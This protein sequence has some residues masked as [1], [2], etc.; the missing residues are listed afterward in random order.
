MHYQAEPHAEAKLIRCTAGAIH[1]VIID[2]R[3][4]SA[5]YTRWD[6]V[7]LTAANRRLLFVPQGFAH[8]FLTLADDTEVFYQISAAYRPEA[9]RGVRWNDPVFGIDW[10][11]SP[12][13]ISRRDASY[14]DY[15]AVKADPALPR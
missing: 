8:G 5:T 13:V 7:E 12:V 3:P 1:D 6:A 10:P 9:A 11:G 4:G 15:A 2:L 14:P